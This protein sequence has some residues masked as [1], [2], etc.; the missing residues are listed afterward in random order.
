MQ[1]KIIVFIE[2]IVIAGS[3]ILDTNKLFQLL[4]ESKDK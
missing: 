2:I 3:I 1:R 4:I